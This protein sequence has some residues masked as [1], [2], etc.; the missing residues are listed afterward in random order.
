MRTI[1]MT[2]PALARPAR[3]AFIHN[4]N[5]PD[6]TVAPHKHRLEWKS[7]RTLP[8]DPQCCGSVPRIHTGTCTTCGY[9]RE[10]G[11]RLTPSDTLERFELFRYPLR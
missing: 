1:G 5:H 6:P 11:T 7:R 3:G 8:N 4:T 9:Q 10:F 2:S